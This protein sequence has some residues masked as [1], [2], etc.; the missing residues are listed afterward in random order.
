MKCNKQLS[1]YGA[2]LYFRDREDYKEL[3]IWTANLDLYLFYLLHMK[4]VPEELHETFEYCG[5]T[6]WYL[7]DRNPYKVGNFI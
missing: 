7:Y 5:N 1:L 6:F 4:N 2:F 3:E